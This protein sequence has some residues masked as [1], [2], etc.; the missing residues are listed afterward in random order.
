MTSQ[1]ADEFAVAEDAVGKVEL[2]LEADAVDLGLDA[3]LAAFLMA[4]S[5]VICV[6]LLCGAIGAS[7][8]WKRC[9]LTGAV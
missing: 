7:S 9:L 4:A 8:S 3:G 6:A 2:E 1:I 5:C